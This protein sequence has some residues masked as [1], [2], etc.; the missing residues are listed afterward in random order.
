MMNTNELLAQQRRTNERIAQQ[1][2]N[3][4]DS[5]NRLM[6]RSRRNRVRRGSFLGRFVGG[7]IKLAIFLGLLWVGAG[8][9]LRTIDKGQMVL[10]SVGAPAANFPSQIVVPRGIWRQPPPT[11]VHHR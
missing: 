5:F 11:V 6:S 7:L 3:F 8:V 2:R 1:N 4:D 9:A 10:P